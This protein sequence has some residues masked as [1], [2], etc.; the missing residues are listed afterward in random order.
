MFNKKKKL[1]IVSESNFFNIPMII[2]SL[3]SILFF[4]SIIY[5][6]INKESDGVN[7]IVDLEKL[8]K[9]NSFEQKTGHRIQVEVLNGCGQKKIALMYKRFLREEGYDVL[10]AKNAHSFD[11]PH[12]KIIYHSENIEMAK[13]LSKLLG[14]NDSLLKNSPDSDLIFDLSIIIGDD[15]N[16]LSSFNEVSLYYPIY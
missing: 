5:E 7:K 1:K 9:I 3:I 6:I 4:S 8:I 12:T 2:L 10:D 13:Y 11:N 14:V 16:E 15:F